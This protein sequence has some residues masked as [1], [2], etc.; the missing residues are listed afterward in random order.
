MKLKLGTRLLSFREERR[1]TQ[2]E[3]AELLQLPVSSYSRIERNENSVEIE[4]I[5]EFANALNI[6]VQE[7]LPETI[8]I[9]NNSHGYG[10]GVIFGNQYYYGVDSEAVKALRAEIDF[11]KR[12]N[13]DL[14]N[15]K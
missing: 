5:L 14:K 3:M 11:L 9:H 2:A 8:S 7:L 12:E 4:K 1:L 6:P 10:G 15:K 13:E